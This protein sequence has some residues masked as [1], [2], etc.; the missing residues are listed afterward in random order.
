MDPET[1]QTP[2]IAA[3]LTNQKLE[4]VKPLVDFNADV[5]K[6]AEKPSTDEQDLHNAGTNDFLNDKKLT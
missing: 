6:E 1:G 3:V 5:N 2:L 4:L